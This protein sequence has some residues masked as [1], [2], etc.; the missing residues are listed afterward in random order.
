MLESLPFS[1]FNGLIW[2]LIISIVALG[3][4]I[5][6][7]TM[8]VVNVAHGELYATGA[9]LGF[10]FAVDYNLNFWL[11]MA[12]AVAVVGVMCAILEKIVYREYEGK[13][14]TT[15]I[16]SIGLALILQQVALI[17]FGGEVALMKAPVEGYILLM[18]QAFPIYRLVAAAMSICFLTAMWY[19]LFRTSVGLSIRATMQDRDMAAGL[20]INI[21]RISM[22]TFGIGGALAALGGVIASPIIS[23]HYLMGADIL[24]ISFIVVI[25]GQLSLKGAI[26]A[27]F[28]FAPLEN[29]LALFVQPIIARVISFVIMCIIVVIR[30][31]NLVSRIRKERIK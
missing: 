16:L 22:L 15:L 2:A 14:R 11:S 19:F 4:S 29:V 25:V 20:G 18:G 5:I 3:L 27:A 1:F 7:G 6:F 26:M 12:L 9:I 17:I 13:V 28:L 10:I 23:V 21:D 24:T 30:Q 8:R 31:T